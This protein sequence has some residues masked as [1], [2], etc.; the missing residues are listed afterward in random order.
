MTRYWCV[1]FDFD[2]CLQHGLKHNLWLMQYQYADDDGNTFQ[3][4]RKSS[5]T[6][7]WRRTKNIQVGDWLVAYLPK[8]RSSTGNS[9]FAVGKVRLPRKPAHPSENV[10]TVEEY[11][12]NRRSHEIESGIVHYSDAQVFYEDFDDAWSPKD[13]PLMKYAQRIDVDRWMLTSMAGVEWLSDLRIGPNEIQR[14][15]FRIGKRNFRQIQQLLKDVGDSHRKRRKKERSVSSKEQNAAA[16]ASERAYSKG[17]GFQ[18]DVRLR[19]AIELYSMNAAK[20]FYKSLGYD[21]VDTSKNHP[22]DLECLR[23][24]EVL[25]VEVKGTQTDGAAIILTEGEVRFA[26]KHVGQMALFLL[27]SIS[28]SSD[29]EVISDGVRQIHMPWLVDD[30]KLDC[31]SYKYRIT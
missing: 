26:R 24:G 27:H 29:G 30:D 23:L 2:E 3:G 6:A 28:V 19:K 9:Y 1:N 18:L 20:V 12:A 22:Y 8:S 4:D 11:V 7:N 25:Y 16:D 14:A 15:F 10:S 13:F 31:L 17:Q 21:V 5:V